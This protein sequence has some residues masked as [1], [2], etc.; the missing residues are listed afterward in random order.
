MPSTRCPNRAGSRSWPS[1]E[2]GSVV[3]RIVDNGPGIPAR[4]PRPHLRSLL[5]DQAGRSRAPGLGL[6]IVRRL[7][8]HNDGRHRRRVAAGTDGVSGHAARR[9]DRRRRRRGVNKPVLL[10]VDDDPQVLAA[11]RRDLRS[12]YREHYTVVERRLGTGGA[13]DG[14][15]AEEPRRFAGDGDQRPAHA[16]HARRRGA[17]PLPRGVPAG[18]ARPADGLFGH[19]GGGQGHQRGA[20]RSLPVEALGSAG[21]TRSSRSSTICSTPGRPSTCPRRRDCGWSGTSGRRGRTRSRTSWRAI[22][23]R[24]A[25]STSSGTPT[26]GRCS[27]RPASVADELPALFFEDGSVLRNPETRQVAERL[28]RPLSAAFE[29]YD[30]V[31]VGAGP[32]GLAAAVYGA[33]EGLR[34]LLLD[35]H[36]PGRAGGHELAH[37]EL[38]R[39]SGRGQRQRAD[40]PRRDAGAAARRRV[41]RAARGDRSV[42]RRRVQAS[43][44][45]RRPRARHANHAGRHRHD[46][47]R[48]SGARRRGAH[49]RRRVLRRRDDRSPGVPRPARARRRRRELRGPGRDVPGALR[50]GGADRGAPRGPPRDDVA[51]PDRADR[52]D[53]EHPRCGL[54][55]KSSESKATATWNG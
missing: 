37:R 54:G 34:T 3:V 32:A 43:D 25:G 35:R 45:R 11:V 17:R 13:R 9:R 44:A 36:A 51:V 6:D 28:G 15:R 16:R 2:A 27:R 55:R 26:R 40:A 30:L 12:R 19:R 23:S 21:G 49:G 47:S 50:R 8:Q 46:L 42:D 33:S 31:I 48:A 4:D 18:P 24:I 14:P 29:V 5:H 10:V 52:Q 41:P 20:P 38:P 39:V 1:R 22:S 53:A 7:V